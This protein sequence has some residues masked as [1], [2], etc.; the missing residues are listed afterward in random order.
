MIVNKLH[1][2]LTVLKIKIIWKQRR[3]NINRSDI[4]ITNV[5]YILATR[6]INSVS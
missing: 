6:G 2:I 1:T 4:N 3:S 5:K